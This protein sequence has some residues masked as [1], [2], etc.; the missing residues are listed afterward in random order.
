MIRIAIT[1]DEDRYADILT[2]YLHRFEREEDYSFSIRRFRD[3]DELTDPYPGDL[4][5]ILMDIE[6][7]FMN[8]MEA[9]EKIR[10]TDEAVVIIFVTNMAQFALRG[11]R[12]QALDYILKPVVYTPF[13]ES[14]KRAV[15]MV[16]DRQVGYLTLRSKN[17]VERLPIPEIRWIESRGHRLTFHLRDR[18]SETTVYTMKELE[19][20][21]EKSGFCRCSSGFL[22][23]LR[24][25]TGFRDNEVIVEGTPIAVSR[26][27]FGC[28]SF[29]ALRDPDSVRTDGRPFVACGNGRGDSCAGRHAK[30]MP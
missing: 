2:Q 26:G 9:A 25:V 28:R 10:E 11:Y 16:A 7:R 3:G 17:T 21:L 30:R 8:G 1:E 24:H 27:R 13:A 19:E 15:R 22:V 12:V 29:C 6:M 14:M 20:Q 18:I 23:N 4:D 5:I